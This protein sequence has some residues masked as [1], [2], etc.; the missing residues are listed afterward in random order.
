M[1]NI[2][3]NIEAYLIHHNNS[4]SRVYIPEVSSL[5]G[6][7]VLVGNFGRDNLEGIT[8][9]LYLEVEGE[10]HQELQKKVKKGK[11][12]Q[13][14]E[15]SERRVNSLISNGRDLGNHKTDFYTDLCCIVG[16]CLKK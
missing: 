13:K 14:F 2:Q 6:K 11:F 4:H 15:V 12:V 8:P 16:H 7:G 5:E 3:L 10:M 1:Y 9:E